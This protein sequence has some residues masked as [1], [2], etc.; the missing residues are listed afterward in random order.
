[1]TFRVVGIDPGQINFSH[2]SLLVK[3]GHAT[4]ESWE[5]IAIVPSGKT[6]YETLYKRLLRWWEKND[7][8]STAD[9]ICV[10]SQFKRPKNKAVEAFVLGMAGQ[11]GRLISSRSWRNYFGL[12]TGSYEN[13]K[14]VSTL[15]MKSALDALHPSAK[16]R[17]DLAESFMIA[18]FGAHKEGHTAFD[19]DFGVLKKMPSKPIKG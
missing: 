11:R 5:N 4:I 13:N 6:T 9:I 19:D 7:S 15:A 2:C 18:C 14:L 8:F 1:M 12:S 16:V 10:E 3:E 17:A